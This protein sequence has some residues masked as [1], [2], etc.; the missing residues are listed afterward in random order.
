MGARASS[1]DNSDIVVRL[2][3]LK[4]LEEA[5]TWLS[6]PHPELDGLTPEDALDRGR[7]VDVERLI[8]MA[9]SGERRAS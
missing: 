4:S 8:T 5:A 7:R 3:R 9:E 6:A 1:I 2:L